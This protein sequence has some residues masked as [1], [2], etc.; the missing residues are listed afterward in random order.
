MCE[1]CEEKD[2]KRFDPHDCVR[3]FVAR[4]AWRR[5]ERSI[6]EGPG[7]VRRLEAR[8]ARDDPPD[9]AA[10]SAET[11]RDALGSQRLPYRCKT[12]RRG[13]ASTARLQGRFVRGRIERTAHHQGRTKW[14]HLC[15]RNPRRPD[16][17]SSR[18]RMARPSQTPTRFLR[19]AFT[20]RSELRSSRK[21]TTRN[22][23]MSPTPTVSCALP[24]IAGDLKAS[25]SPETVVAN[26]P[27]GRTHSTRDIAFTQT[28]SGC[29][30]PLARPAMSAEGMGSA[31]R[32]AGGMEPRASARRRLGLRDRSCSGAVVRSRRQG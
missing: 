6:A 25:E 28:A 12:S 27:H 22:L 17:R 5:G 9:Q 24:T 19:A 20:V 18:R 7:S 3:T 32:R 8:Q 21:A 1:A 23:S 14:R 31:A 26:L 29:W 15:R 11:G 16:S 13:S 4:H 10:G 30:S 2:A